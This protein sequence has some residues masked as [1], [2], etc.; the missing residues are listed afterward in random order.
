MTQRPDTS[1][2][3]LRGVVKRFG[4]QTVLD[5]LSLDVPRGEFLAIVGPSGS[6]KTTAMR[7]IGGFETPD[8]GSVWISGEDVTGLPAERR[9]VNTVFQSYALFPHLSV[10][11]NVAY[12]PRMRGVPRAERRRQAGELLELVR[13]SGAAD[14]KPAQLSGGMQ[15]RVA[16]ARALAN[17]PAVLLLDE[18]LGALDRKLREEMQRELRRIQTELGATFIYITHDQEEAFGMADR[19]A[20]MRDGRFAQIGDPATLYDQ[21]ADAWVALFLGSANRIAATV[22]EGDA[23]ASDLGPLEASH[24]SADLAAGDRALVIVRPEQTR[25]SRAAVAGPN[26]IS[27]RLVDA[28][29]LGPSL[30]LR[31]VTAGGTEFE[32]IEPRGDVPSAD[33]PLQPGDPVT[34]S[35]DASAARA[36]RAEPLPSRPSS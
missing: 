25:F 5:G 15:Q 23:L 31:A 33:A 22:G 12:G 1:A 9:D 8:E 3:A 20:V 36:Y 19:L 34:V 6:G 35:F 10:L 32:S 13:L 27:A 26:A 29:A 18:P 21:P 30:R 14:R 7:L 16:L 24:V 17:Q 28:V 2:V 11:D 4:E